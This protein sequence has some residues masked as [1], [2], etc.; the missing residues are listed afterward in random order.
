MPPPCAGGYNSHFIFGEHQ[1]GFQS[2]SREARQTRLRPTLIS[3]DVFGTLI[4]VRK[5]SYD[6]FERI[7]VETGAHRST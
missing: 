5:I 7:L 1:A 4:S 6:A 2:M 3:F